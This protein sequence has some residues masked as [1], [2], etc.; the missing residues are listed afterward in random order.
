M[1]KNIVDIKAKGII[2]ESDKMLFIDQEEVIKF[3]NKNKIFIKGIS[4]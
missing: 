3:A 4:V 1:I 2:L